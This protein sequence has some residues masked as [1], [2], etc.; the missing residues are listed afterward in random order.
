MRITRTDYR[1]GIRETRDLNVTCQQLRCWKNGLI[2]QHAFPCI[3]SEDREWMLSRM[4]FKEWDN[5][6]ECGG[7]E[8]SKKHYIAIAAILNDLETNEVARQS[9]EGY[10]S[11][12]I[13]KLAYYFQN[14]NVNFKSAKFKAACYASE[15][16]ESNA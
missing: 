7:I 5:L 4:T 10:K 6:T 11:V 1:T 16:E 13:S 15:K 14:E 3:T 2:E 9:V 8:M 12:L